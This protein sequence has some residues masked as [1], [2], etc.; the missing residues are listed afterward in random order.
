VSDLLLTLEFFRA[1][2][3]RRDQ[4]LHSGKRRLAG[5]F[6]QQ[7]HVGKNRQTMAAY[8]RHLPYTVCTSLT[9]H[10]LATTQSSKTAYILQ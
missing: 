4:Q 3:L 2:K 9:I 5:G 7:S 8:P 10:C 1:G 6:H